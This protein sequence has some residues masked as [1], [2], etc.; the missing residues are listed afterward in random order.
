MATRAPASLK[1]TRPKKNWSEEIMKEEEG[2]Q[3]WDGLAKLVAQPTFRRSPRQ[4]GGRVPAVISKSSSGVYEALASICDPPKVLQRQKGRID[5]RMDYLDRLRRKLFRGYEEE[6]CWRTPNTR[7]DELDESV[8]AEEMNRGFKNREPA[9]PVHLQK[10]GDMIEDLVDK[11]LVEAYRDDYGNPTTPDL[12]NSAWNQ[13]R[14]LRSDGYPRYRPAS[15]DPE[16][17][18][19]ARAA[20]NQIN[21]NIMRDWAVLQKHYAA[22]RQVSQPRPWEVKNYKNKREYFIGKICH[23]L[24]V[25]EYLPGIQNYNALIS[26]FLKLG[27]HKLARHVVESFRFNSHLRPTQMT[28]AAMLHY[29]RVQEATVTGDYRVTGDILGFY[30]FLGRLTGQ[31]ARGIGLGRR[32]VDQV[33]EDRGVLNWARR[34]DVAMVDGFVVEIAKIDKAVAEAVLDGLLDFDQPRQAATVL[35]A[36]LREGLDIDSN[37]LRRVVVLCNKLLD[38]VAAMIILRELIP[39]V[40]L[41]AMVAANPS[42]DFHQLVQLLDIGDSNAERNL[43]VPPRESQWLQL[44]DGINWKLRIGSLRMAM[45]I[46]HTLARIEDIRQWADKFALFLASKPTLD[47]DNINHHYTGIDAVLKKHNSVQASMQTF[48]RLARLDWITELCRIQRQ[49]LQAYEHRMMHILLVPIPQRHRPSTVFD[50]KVAL[51][52][53]LQ[54]IGEITEN[55]PWLRQAGDCV[56]RA[57]KLE[58]QMKWI[59]RNYLPEEQKTAL[60][61]LDKNERPTFSYYEALEEWSTY[62]ARLE[63]EWT[64]RSSTRRAISSSKAVSATVRPVETPDTDLFTSTMLDKRFVPSH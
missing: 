7:I 28:V 46:P 29:Y 1:A 40:Q 56:A 57:Q 43:V 55:L 37:Y 33:R 49:K 59:L 41:S 14:M 39:L 19:E 5:T 2:D 35:M 34:S 11:L 15:H 26:G 21:R 10:F 48:R 30:T 51:N 64:G 12:L 44:N 52:E 23:N 3:V 54:L 62:L 16:A 18:A 25:V 45:E 53:R 61:K 13:V 4:A 50:T 17:A 42:S 24:L 63:Q 60:T 31:D 9:T 20:L 58:R 27:E 36:C 22:L 6:A 47:W 8:A 38:R 32:P